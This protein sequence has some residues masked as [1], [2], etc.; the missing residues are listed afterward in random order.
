MDCKIAAG[1]SPKIIA[2]EDEQNQ[3]EPARGGRAS[4]TPQGQNLGTNQVMLV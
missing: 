3:R 2:D 4:G 1:A